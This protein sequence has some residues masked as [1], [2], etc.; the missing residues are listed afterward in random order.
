MKRFCTAFWAGCLLAGLAFAAPAAEAKTPADQLVVGTSLS[1]VLTLDPQ[2]AT[3]PKAMEILANLYDRLVATTADGKVIPQLAESWTLDDKGI[4]FKLRAAKFASGNPVTAKDVVFSLSRLL[5]LDQSGAGYMKRIGFS[6]DNIDSQVKAVDDQTV[7]LDATPKVTSELLLYRLALGV[8]SVVDSVEVQKHV[9]DNDYG[10]AWLRTNSAGSGPFTLR[11]WTPNEIIILDANADY[12]G[13]KPELKRVVMRHVP[14]SQVER[15]MLERGDIDVASA[16]SA[17]DLATFK[18]K[19][20]FTIQRVPTGGFYVLAMN[21]GNQ[22]L[23]NPK[24]R[25]AIAYGIDYQGI[26]KTIMGLYGTVRNVPVPT[27]FADAI[28]NPDWHFDVEKAKALLAE[29]G[30]KDGF[31]LTLKTI[32]QTPR[33]DLATA[34]QASLGQIGIKI[35]IQQGNGSEII[36]AHRARKFDM[37]IPQ[38]GALMPN[39]LG[40]MEDFD[41]NPDNSLAA[42]NAGSFAWRSAWDVADLTKL[43]GTASVEP[44]PKK[45]SEIYVQMQKMFLDLK[46]ALLPLFERFEPIVVSNEV[47]GFVGHP[48]QMTRLD[49]VSKSPTN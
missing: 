24:V 39:V 2:Q 32:A 13:G 43:A 36:A 6:A 35:E 37:V 22:Y 18:E 12:A 48:N 1:Q 10:N 14:E 25:E 33:I 34:L 15:L 26:E 31:S 42:N 38:S 49:K 20:G 19:P 30:Y 17:A 40:S 8:T 7:R 45:R 9:K 41:N 46:P 21:A 5:K 47:H 16:M 28:E 23:A 4:T 29:A 27:R 3:E 44:D 11:K